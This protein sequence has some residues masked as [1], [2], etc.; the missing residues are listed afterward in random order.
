MVSEGEHHEECV[1]YD[2][3]KFMYVDV[4]L[5]TNQG[6]FFP[7]G[8]IREEGIGEAPLEAENLTETAHGDVACIRLSQEIGILGDEEAEGAVPDSWLLG[9]EEGCEVS[10]VTGSSVTNSHGASGAPGGFESTL[11]VG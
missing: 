2:P 7:R 4:P 6:L 5:G 8:K 10:E 3:K 11:H 1:D 9:Y